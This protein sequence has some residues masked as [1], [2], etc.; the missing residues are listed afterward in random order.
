MKN[1]KLIH[2]NVARRSE[3]DARLARMIA[4]RRELCATAH[5]K[6]EA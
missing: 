3:A 1:N 2:Y 4:S 5:K 6:R